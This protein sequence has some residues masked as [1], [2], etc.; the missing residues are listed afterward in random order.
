MRIANPIYDVIFKYLL[1]DLEIA[2][3]LLSKIINEEITHIEVQA[4]ESTSRSDKFDIIIF[5]LDFKALIKGKDG[6]LKK[7]LI[8][9]QKGKNPTDILRFRRYLGDNYRKEDTIQDDKR[10]RKTSLPI[11]TI[12]FLGFNLQTIKSPIIKVNR[13]YIDLRTSQKIETR[14]EFIEKLSHDS[15][16][17]QIRRLSSETQ[18]ELEKVLQIF[19]QRYITND[20]KILEI[21]PELIGKNM[22]LLK[23]TERLRRAATEE[24]ILNKAELVEEV[25][26][27]IEQHIRE[28]QDALEE[29]DNL[30]GENDN[31][32]GEND[33][34]K[35]KNDNLKG[36]NDNLKGKNDNLKG[37]NDDLKGEND[38]L[39]KELERL[40]KL[41]DKNKGD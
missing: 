15:F 18:T 32:K 37:K 4:Q 19:N 38:D 39:K 7:V 11:L 5:R 33:N 27:V 16:I 29:N 30:K 8:E 31:L 14:E 36:K 22:L 12:Y 28:K 17:I 13:E 2:R 25:E 3:L 40:N 35:G 41:M 10:D 20:N 23:M 9:L 34:L 24:Q 21:D 26:N 6:K 1:E